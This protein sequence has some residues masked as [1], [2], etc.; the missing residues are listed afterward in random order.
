MTMT[1]NDP[2]HVGLAGWGGL[3]REAVRFAMMRGRE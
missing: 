2:D 1:V 3:D